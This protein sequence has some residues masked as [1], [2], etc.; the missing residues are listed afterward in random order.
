MSLTPQTPSG[1]QTPISLSSSD[2]SDSAEQVLIRV[3]PADFKPR[4][5]FVDIDV[6]PEKTPRYED[7]VH[8]V[9]WNGPDDPENPMNWPSY[10]KWLTI[11]LISF[12]SFNV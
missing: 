10:R 3:H 7:A 5:G 8:I 1:A 4:D 2:G 6:D 11:G 12:S 9:D